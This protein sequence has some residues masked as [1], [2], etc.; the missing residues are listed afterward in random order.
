[1]V[2]SENMYTAL[3]KKVRGGYIAWLEEISGVLTQG[4]SLSEA[5]ENLKDALREMLLARRALT[6][7]QLRGL[8][9]S[10]L[11]SHNEAC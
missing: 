10:V 9:A 2:Y 1:V 5:K 6:R 7:R 8:C 3:Y 11:L 4:A